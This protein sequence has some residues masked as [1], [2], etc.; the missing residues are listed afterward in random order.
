MRVR[1]I[2][3]KCGGSDWQTDLN[4]SGCHIKLS[5]QIRAHDAIRFLVVS[6]GLF[7]DLEL[8]LSGPLS[9]F[10]LVGDVRI[11]LSK[12]DKRRICAWGD[13]VW[14]AGIGEG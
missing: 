13:D 14:D 1:K 10:N 8:R 3:G 12:V 6:K 7:K 9:M 11:E 5:C 4:A 2:R